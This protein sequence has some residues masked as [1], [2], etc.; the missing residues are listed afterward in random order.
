VIDLPTAPAKLVA[1]SILSSDFSRLGEQIG[2]IEA[3]G[4]DWVHVDVM[5]G[6]FVP[7]ITIGIPV[8]KCI[9]PVTQLP[10][11]VHLMIDNPDR[12]VK[13]FA[14]AGSD[15][16]TVHYEACTHLQRTLTHI[17]DCGARAGVSLNPHT[18]IDGLQYVLDE[19]D[20]ILIMSVNPG[21]GGQSF[22][23]STLRKLRDL[24]EMMQRRGKRVLVEVDGGVSPKNCAAVRSAG[25][26]VLVAGSAVFKSDDYT[27]VISA[28]KD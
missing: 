1:P 28:L 25:A 24:G 8:V 16:I 17:R 23:P 11:D 6:S 22:I 18:P 15:I 13:A 27:G 19:L 14:E 2:E 10:L 4:A 9:R 26:D 12:H 21:F 20:M 7:N 3:A 5:D